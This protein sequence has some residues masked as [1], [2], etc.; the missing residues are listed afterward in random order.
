MST[1]GVER[2]RQHDADDDPGRYRSEVD[3]EGD[4]DDDDHHDRRRRSRPTGMSRWRQPETAPTTGIDS[5]A[6]GGV[7]GSEVLRS[8]GGRRGRQRRDRDRH[9]EDR[10][11]RTGQP[12]EAESHDERDGQ[13]ERTRAAAG[14]SDVPGVDVAVRV[15]TRR[16]RSGRRGC[17]PRR[18]SANRRAMRRRPRACSRRPVRRSERP[19]TSRPRSRG[20][21]CPAR[22]NDGGDRE[23]DRTH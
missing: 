8:A 4:G 20:Q 9:Q 7:G 6:A 14:G 19:P 2:H 22:S 13:P 1:S 21:S 10:N 18:R 5:V 12:S 17:R 11:E 3:H 16:R 23:A 15:P